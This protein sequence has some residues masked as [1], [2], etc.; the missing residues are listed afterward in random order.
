MTLIT[1]HSPIASRASLPARLLRP[2]DEGASAVEFGLLFPLMLTAV[3]GIA[4]MGRLSYT[5]AAL[6]FAAQ[7]ATRFAI[8]REGQVSDSEIQA[9]ASQRLISLNQ[10][11]A[12][13]T[14]TSP[15]SA[16]TGTSLI[17]VQVSYP[18]RFMLPLVSIDTITLTAQSSGFYAFPGQGA[19]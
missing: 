17:T 11:L 6:F 1:R 5:Q 3:L 8:V 16:V 14:A 18:F 12:V 10:G 2:G 15:V 4:E 9:F 7:E 13:V 19:P